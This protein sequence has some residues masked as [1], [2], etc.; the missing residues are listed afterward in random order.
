[1]Y[2]KGI[3]EILERI[4]IGSGGQWYAYYPQ[5]NHEGSVTLLTDTS[6][7]VIERYRYDAFGAPSIYTGTWGTRSNTI[8]DNRFLFTGREYAVTYRATTT[9]VF[10]FYEYRA[11]AYNPK[12][13]RFMSEDPKLFDA[14][15]YN[16]FRYCHNDPIDMTDPMG[17]FDTHHI[18][19]L[20]PELEDYINNRS[21][22]DNAQ[23]AMAKWADS[24]NNFQGQFAQF[25]AGQG[26]TMGQVRSIDGHEVRRATPVHNIAVFHRSTNSIAFFFTDRT[27]LTCPAANRTVNPHGDPNRVDSNSPAPNGTFPV[28]PPVPTGSSI[29]YGPYFYP[30]GA[31][32]PNGERL[33]I[34]RERGI[35]LHG[36]RDNYLYPTH[37]CIR[38]N[39]QDI[40]NLHHQNENAPLQSI[41][42][43][44]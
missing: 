31:V 26:L 11:R 13:G 22:N 42:I 18:G 43:G 1:V 14:G 40:I 10:N 9:P 39:N 2:G 16:L 3:D 15:D 32:G 24:S 27:I 29:S 28:Q 17:L 12:L 8:Y 33:D 23:W 30:I 34:A 20:T 41:T 4:A 7:T 6:G 38:M 35:G 36:G 44:N 19:H 25:A 5:Q 37:G 21:G